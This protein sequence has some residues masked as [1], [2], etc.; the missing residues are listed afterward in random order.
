M[1]KTKSAVVQNIKQLIDISCNA[2][3]SD[4]WF[5]LFHLRIIKMAYNA[6]EVSIDYDRKRMYMNVMVNEDYYN[7]YSTKTS[8]PTIAVNLIYTDLK[9]FLNTCILE[10][11]N[12]LAI[13]PSIM[14]NFLNKKS[15]SKK[16]KEYNAA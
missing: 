4:S 12:S 16:Q 1:F 14:A 7:I 10:D 2:N 13:Y 9:D 5:R 15:I 8:L 11:D 3:K 6:T